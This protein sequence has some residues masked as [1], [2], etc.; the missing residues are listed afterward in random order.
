MSHNSLFK[1]IFQTLEQQSYQGRMIA[2]EHLAE[3]QTEIEQR[4]YQGEMARR[5]MK[6]NLVKSLNLPPRQRCQRPGP[7]LLQGPRSHGWR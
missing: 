2:V 3:L 4:Y 1:K 5:F 6:R 7:S